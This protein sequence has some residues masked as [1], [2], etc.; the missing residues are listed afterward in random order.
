MLREMKTINVRRGTIINASAKL[1][2]EWFDGQVGGMRVFYLRVFQRGELGP[3]MIYEN[4]FLTVEYAR[5]CMEEIEAA[6]RADAAPGEEVFVFPGKIKIPSAN[7]TVVVETQGPDL[8]GR[9]G[10]QT[11]AAWDFDDEAHAD[12]KVRYEAGRWSDPT[13]IIR[14]IDNRQ[15]KEES[16]E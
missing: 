15:T 9:L 16:H 5:Y 4:W 8:F 13:V 6:L 2:D 3:V 11:R 10:L 1:T 7:F 14:K 12:E